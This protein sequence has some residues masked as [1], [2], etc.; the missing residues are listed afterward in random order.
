M[1]IA[2]RTTRANWAEALAPR[3]VPSLI[4][5]VADPAGDNRRWAHRRTSATAGYIYGGEIVDPVNCVILDTSSTGAR[6]EVRALRGSRFHNINDLPKTFTI[7][8]QIDRVALDCSIAWRRGSEL[9]IKFTSP[10]RTI[11][12]RKRAIVATRGKK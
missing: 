8:F 3:K 11:A 10:A 6:I 9:G 7:V 12:A 5:I 1:T 4:G 2:V